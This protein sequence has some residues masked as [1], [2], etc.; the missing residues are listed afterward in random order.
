VT[1]FSVN[2]RPFDP[3]SFRNFSI[4]L[5]S[6]VKKSSVGGDGSLISMVFLVILLI[7]DNTLN[8]QLP[9]QRRPLSQTSDPT[10]DSLSSKLTDDSQQIF[11]ITK[12]LNVVLKSTLCRNKNAHIFIFQI[13]LSTINRF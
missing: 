5:P 4:K 9:L 1:C 12:L 13:T 8:S 2:Y 11:Q 7:I 6:F 3:C 10:R